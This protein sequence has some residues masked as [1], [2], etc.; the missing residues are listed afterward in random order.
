LYQKVWSG[1]RVADDETNRLTSILDFSQ[2]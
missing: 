1:R 2:F